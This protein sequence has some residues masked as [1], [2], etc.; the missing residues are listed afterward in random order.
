MEQRVKDTEVD[1]EIILEDEGL[2][3]LVDI[4]LKWMLKNIKQID[5]LHGTLDNGIQ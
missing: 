3:S 5:S 1:D 4:I 2:P